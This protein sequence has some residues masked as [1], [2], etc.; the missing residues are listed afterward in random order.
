MKT[1]LIVISLNIFLT[2]IATI[3]APFELW[4]KIIDW[5]YDGKLTKQFF[6][7]EDFRK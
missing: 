7:K 1:K 4:V 3:F 6:K 2:I 5:I